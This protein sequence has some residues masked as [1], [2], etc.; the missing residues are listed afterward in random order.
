MDK[1]QCGADLARGA[2]MAQALSDLLVRHHAVIGVTFMDARL[3][4]LRDELMDA[5]YPL[6]P[7]A[8]DAAH[9][10]LTP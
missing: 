3:I 10:E 6:N 2:L 1:Q 5:A 7:T 9:R 8:W 4:A